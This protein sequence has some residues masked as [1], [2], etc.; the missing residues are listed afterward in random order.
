M[1]MF[2]LLLPFSAH[3]EHLLLVLLDDMGWAEYGF[4]GALEVL[5]P[6]MDRLA[7]EYTVLEQYYTLPSC[8]PARAA[9]LTG[10]SG[11]SIH[12]LG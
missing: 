5:T 4:H 9:I 1:F 10:V 2:F 7:G 11:Y 3:T 12:V 6:T 8:S